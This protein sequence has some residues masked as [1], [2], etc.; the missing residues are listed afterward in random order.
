MRGNI[1]VT[2]AAAAILVW[3]TSSY[4]A[5]DEKMA[6]AEATEHGCLKCHTVDA[7]KIGPAYKEVAAKYKGK[8]P[9]ELATMMKSKPVHAAVLKKVDDPHLKMLTEWILSM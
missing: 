1:A 6:V 7:K 8:T 3:Q 2:I 9:A 4:A 5:V